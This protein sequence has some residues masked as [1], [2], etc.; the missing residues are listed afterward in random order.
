[1]LFPDVLFT[2]SRFVQLVKTPLEVRATPQIK[3]T[4]FLQKTKPEKLVVISWLAQFP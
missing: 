1:M 3:L 4:C 2:N